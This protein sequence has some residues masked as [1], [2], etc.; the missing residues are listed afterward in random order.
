[1]L[2]FLYFNFSVS[3]LGQ[4]SKRVENEIQDFYYS[5]IDSVSDQKTSSL[6]SNTS[7]VSASESDAEIDKEQADDKNHNSEHS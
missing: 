6:E 3:E 5:D 1:M 2:N 7:S 4:E